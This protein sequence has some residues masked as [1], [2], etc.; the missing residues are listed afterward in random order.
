M[1]IITVRPATP[2]DLAVIA[3]YNTRLAA[4]TEDKQLDPATITA[5]VRAAL[6]K[7]DACR[8]FI[9]ESDGQI[10]GQAMVTFEW[11]DWRNGWFWWFQ[12]VYVDHRFRRLGVFRALHEHIRTRAMSTEGVRGLRLYVDAHNTRAQSTYAAL[13][14]HPSGHL[15]FEEDWSNGS[16]PA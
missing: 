6:A 12:S 5:G 10:A 14:M 8:Y 2:A 15:V 9:A 4:E 7:P 1:P 16:A 11:T 13:G 3:D